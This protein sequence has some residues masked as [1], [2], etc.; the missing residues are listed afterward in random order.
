MKL[1]DADWAPSPRRVRIYLAEKQIT[2]ERAVIDLR[3]DEQFS[4]A[5]LA[6]NP[7]GIVPA[8]QFDDGEVLCE[9]AAICRYFEA[10]GD[11]SALF[12][13]TPR[14]IAR[15]ESWT[16][17]I[18]NE[19]YAAVVYVLRNQRAAFRDRGVAGKWPAIP[20]IPELV[21]RGRLMWD[22]FMLG[23]DTHLASRSW[24][25]TEAYSFADISA[26][27]TVDFAKAVRLTLPDRA[28]HVARWHAAATARPSAAA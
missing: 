13:E 19:A 23:L 6:M 16:R 28:N 11:P 5:Y 10:M 20:Q 2:V 17:R 4:E 26:L 18:E 24:I 7:R 15:I 21:E 1:F 3:E 22:A 27:V 14:D 9:S 12:G 8:L 25:A